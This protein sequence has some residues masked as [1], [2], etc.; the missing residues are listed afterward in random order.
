MGTPGLYIVASLPLDP[1]TIVSPR[2]HCAVASVS[3]GAH[4]AYTL[5]GTHHW[6]YAADCRDVASQFF[7]RLLSFARFPV[8]PGTGH[9][10]LFTGCER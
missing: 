8:H 5:T 9:C 4:N 1:S 10:I 3:P 2:D 7:Q 6:V